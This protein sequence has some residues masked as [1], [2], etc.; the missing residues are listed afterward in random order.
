MEKRLRWK[1]FFFGLLKH[2]VL[3]HVTYFYQLKYAKSNDRLLI[4]NCSKFRMN[5]PK[6]FY[7]WHKCGKISNEITFYWNVNII[8]ILSGLKYTWISYILW[9]FSWKTDEQFIEHLGDRIKKKKRNR[10]SENLHFNT[11][12]FYVNELNDSQHNMNEI[13]TPIFK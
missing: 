1:C 5:L 6:P 12:I 11:S 7:S 10:F 4:D 3:F 8:R 13:D 2:W 9:G